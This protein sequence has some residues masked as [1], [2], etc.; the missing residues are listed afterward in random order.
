MLSC[1]QKAK[2]HNCLKL[3]TIHLYKCTFL[4]EVEDLLGE[5]VSYATEEVRG[6]S[7]A[8]VE[9]LLFSKDKERRPFAIDSSPNIF[10][11]DF[12]ILTFSNFECYLVVKK[13]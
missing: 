3:S 9:C 8:Q 12:S 13:P 11:E 10:V 6:T 4:I 7:I 5:L 2:N 1:S